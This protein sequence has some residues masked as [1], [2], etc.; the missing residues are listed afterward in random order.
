MNDF[1]VYAHYRLDNNQ[2]FYIGKGRGSRAYKIHGRSEY[3]KRVSNKYG[4]R[5]EILFDNLTEDEAFQVEK[6]SILELRY[7]GFNLVNMTNG[8]EGSSGIVMSE[9]TKLKMSKAH[10][11][12]KRTKEEIEKSARARRGLKKSPKQIESMRQR[13]L[14]HEF[15]EETKEKFR[16][17]L[18]EN[19]INLDTNIYIFLHKNED[20][21]IGTRR[22][23]CRYSNIGIQS[24]RNL[25][26]K[27]KPAPSAKGWYL[28]APLL[29]QTM[30]LIYEKENLK[31]DYCY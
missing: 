28:I 14:G 30:F 20:I 8:G 5:V 11:G 13:M 7:F 21:F 18:L 9:E 16:Q 12:R 29:L 23:L 22:D 6:D 17:R 4:H 19:P 10:T 1:Y 26:S 15:S 27:N 25:F 3:W 2:P 24:I 31:Y